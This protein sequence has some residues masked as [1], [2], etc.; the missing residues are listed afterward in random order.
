MILYIVAAAFV[1]DM[2]TGFQPLEVDHTRSVQLSETQGEQRDACSKT[3]TA[4][5]EEEMKKWAEV[6]MGE[7]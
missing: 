2:V 3:T 7:R 6:C 4:E 5:T 1:L